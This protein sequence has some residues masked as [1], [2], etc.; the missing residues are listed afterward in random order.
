MQICM[1]R[2]T[3]LHTE[4]HKFE[5]YSTICCDMKLKY[6]VP[7]FCVQVYVSRGVLRSVCL[8]CKPNNNLRP[9]NL[10]VVCQSRAGDAAVPESTQLSEFREYAVAGG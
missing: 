7:L 3:N 2:S 9:P 4:V 8:N 6:S 10:C 5:R 1:Q